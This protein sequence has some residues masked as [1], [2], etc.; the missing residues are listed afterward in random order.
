MLNIGRGRRREHPKDTTSEGVT[1]PSVTTGDVQLPVAHAHTQGV[2]WPLITSGSHVTTVLLLRKK[3]GGNRACAEH[4][5][6]QGR[7]RTGS[8]P[9]TWLLLPMK[10]VPLGRILCNFRLRMRRR[11][12]RTWHI[13]DI[14]SGDV[15]IVASGSISQHLRKCDL[16]C[17]HILLIFYI[18]QV[19]IWCELLSR[20]GEPVV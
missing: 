18:K 14:T 20:G 13:A 16:S 19:W 12:F 1:W 4:T 3:R 9:V 15:T 11:Y 10:K 7:F 8:L 6:G 17:V 2:K 5:S